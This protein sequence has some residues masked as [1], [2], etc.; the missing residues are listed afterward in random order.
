MIRHISLKTRQVTHIS[1][2]NI[3]SVSKDEQD[4]VSVDKAAAAVA[5][6]DRMNQPV[7]PEI[8]QREQPE[9]LRKYFRERSQAHRLKGM[10][11]GDDL[12]VLIA[13]L[14]YWLLT[15]TALCSTEKKNIFV[16]DIPGSYDAG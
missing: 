14:L 11:S 13:V 2:L 4:K 1:K 5:W 6:Q 15:G 9:H 7:V 3:A 12:K 10:L 16:P 8:A